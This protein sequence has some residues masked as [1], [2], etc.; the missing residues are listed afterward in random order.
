MNR[1]AT[2]GRFWPTTSHSWLARGPSSAG[3]VVRRE[4]TLV[5]LRSWPRTPSTWTVQCSAFDSGWSTDANCSAR[6]WLH[7]D[8]RAPRIRDGSSCVARC[9]GIELGSGRAWGPWVGNLEFVGEAE[10]ARSWRSADLVDG[11]LDG[12]DETGGNVDPSFGEAV[13][14]GVVT[15]ISRRFEDGRASM[16]SRTHRRP[17]PAPRSPRRTGHVADAA[18]LGHVG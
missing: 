3:I 10:A 9:I 1:A 15:V 2:V 16:Q 17:G 5:R 11:A 18:A 4:V 6:P 7:D 13:G 14:D 8:K 12:V